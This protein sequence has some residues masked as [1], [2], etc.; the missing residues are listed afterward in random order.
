MNEEDITT[1]ESAGR[2]CAVCR[3]GRHWREFD[4][5]RAEGRDPVVLCPACHARYGE[6]PPLKAG[7]EAPAPPVPEPKAQN[8]NQPQSQTQPQAEGALEPGEPERVGLVLFATIQGIS[9]LVTAGIVPAAQ[10][11]E[12]VAD[13]T[14]GFLAGARAAAASR[15]R[16]SAA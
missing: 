11:D 2:R 9:A 8:H 16:R 14:A 6:T 13:A 15:R 12:L 3:S 7:Q 10:V 4:V 1:I 5:V